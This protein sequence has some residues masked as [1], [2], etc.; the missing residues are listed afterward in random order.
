MTPPLRV[1][2]VD[3]QSLVRAGLSMLLGSEET[4]EIVGEAAN[5]EE[6]VTLVVD[7]RPDVALMDIR[8]P[9]LDGVQATA[10]IAAM[11]GLPTRVLVLTTFDT[12]E[13]VM[14]ALRAGASGYLLKDTEPNDLIRAVHAV[15][16][17]DSVLAPS[18]MRRLLDALGDP[19]ADAAFGSA[20]SRSDFDATEASRP[21]RGEHSVDPQATDLSYL[22]DREL[23]VLT[24]IGEGLTNAE[25]AARLV[26]AES[27]AKTHVGRILMKLHARDR[28]Q[29]VIIAHRAGL[30]S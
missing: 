14:Q 30:V 1:V 10:R 7:Q 20:S 6:G 25:I 2:I 4:I 11:T 23:E 3:D 26:V 29:A 5:G 27:T 21:K 28:V 9:I 12:D 16:A 22:T 13:A 24:L 18:A 19:P 15:A 8:M 17:G